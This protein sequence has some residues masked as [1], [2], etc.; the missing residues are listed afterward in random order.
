MK[1]RDGMLAFAFLTVSGVIA[2]AMIVDPKGFSIREWQTLLAAFVALGA[3]TLAYRA[4]MAKV[5]FDREI[6]DREKR[7]NSR[8]ITLRTQHTAF[9]TLHDAKHSIAALD[10][11]AAG[12][13]DKTIDTKEITVQSFKDFDEAWAALDRFPRRIVTLL[14]EVRTDFMNVEYALKLNAEDNI[15]IKSS[16][17]TSDPLAVLQRNLKRLEGHCET[18]YV[19][20]REYGRVLDD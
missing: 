18:L 11:P 20:L 14:G 12:D 19:S 6:S 1:Y 5:E 16:C 13:P 4:A 17:S 10:P 2:V 15:T 9:V 7:R 3:A 8:G